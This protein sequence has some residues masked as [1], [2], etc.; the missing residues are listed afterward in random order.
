MTRSSANSQFF[1]LRGMPPAQ[2]QVAG[3]AYRLVSVFKH[4]FWAATCLYEL[5][6]PADASHM[7]RIVVKFGRQQ[8]FCGL[9]L[10]WTAQFLADHEESIYRRLAGLAGV[11]RWAGRVGPSAYAIEYLDARP[12]DHFD[13]TPQGFFDSLR[14]IFDALHDRGVAYCDGNKR[15]NI[16]VGPDGQPFLVDY[17][18]SI[19]HRDDLPWPLRPLWN[20]VVRYMADK[21]FYH[22]YKHKRRLSPRELTAEELD[23]SLQR[24]PLVRLH[25]K[26]SK[27]YRA[28]RRGFLRR[29]YEKGMLVSPTAHLEDHHQPEKATWRARKP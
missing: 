14:K 22:L 18:L 8:D 9:P 11:P 13:V 28:L 25:R 17:Q 2:V 23:L 26:L 6:G 16:L 15:S 3:A 24:G 10:V 4:D 12:L 20:A 19:R 27:P 29:R 1:A 5:S 7:P 21:D